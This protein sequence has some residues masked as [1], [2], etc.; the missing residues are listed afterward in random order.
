MSKDKPL[1]TF[2][3]EGKEYTP[4]DKVTKLRWIKLNS[5]IQNGEDVGVYVKDEDGVEYY[6][7]PYIVKKCIIKYN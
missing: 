3:L 1:F 7:Q 2:V 5:L 4:I 6:F